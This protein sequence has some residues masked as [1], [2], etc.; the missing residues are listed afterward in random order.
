MDSLGGMTFSFSVGEIAELVEAVSVE[1]ECSGAVTGLAS[2]KAAL[3]GDLSFL[4]HKR[5]A[6]E[7]AATRA[8]VVLLPPD[9]P[10]QPAPGQAVLRVN[11]PNEAVSR[12]CRKLEVLLWP[13]EP[14]GVHPTAFID[15]SAQVDPGA[16]IGPRCCIEAHAVVGAGSRLEAGVVV[17]RKSRVGPDCWIGWSTV[18]Y[19]ECTV[20]ARVRIHA[21][22][23]IGADGFGYEFVR[24]RHQKVP[25]VGT[26][27]VEDDVE[28]GANA[29]VDRG[30]FGPTIIGAGS[31]LDN[32]VQI[33]HNCTLG[34][35]CIIVA[36]VGIA[37]STV[38]G[39]YVMIGG[40][41][42][43]G[44]HLEIGTAAKIA[45]QS[46]VGHDVPAKGYV[47]GSPAIE[48]LRDQ[49]FQLL[50]HKFPEALRR[51]DRI[52]ARLGT[53]GTDNAPS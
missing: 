46:G 35:H 24:G 37:G 14:A 15:P 27:V 52:E 44:G 2:L 36:Q 5:Y 29:C 3:P 13:K 51:L 45:A 33:G 19:P 25:Q 8:S 31:K 12:I 40:Q 4:A 20:G 39:D 50:R 47:M 1:G 7:L 28:I 18:I 42:G 32:L 41:A 11:Q 16:S 17:G 49:K 43:I 6:P 9:F 21:G 30:R 23:V 10:H 26:V 22:A 48:A 53:V 38:L 34:R